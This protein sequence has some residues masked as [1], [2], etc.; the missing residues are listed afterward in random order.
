MANNRPR[1]IIWFE[2]LFWLSFVAVLL[3]EIIA[4]FGG[5]ATRGL[6]IVVEAAIMLLLWYLIAVEAKDW[7]RWLYIV[8]TAVAIVMII[9]IMIEATTVFVLTAL[10]YISVFASVAAAG[11][12]LRIDAMLWCAKSAAIGKT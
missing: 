11:F 8:L 2:R 1:S 3:D 10:S 5:A 12:L 9:V 4:L 6:S 7:A